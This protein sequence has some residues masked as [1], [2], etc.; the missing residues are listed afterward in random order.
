MMTMEAWTTDSIN[1]FS[2][3]TDMMMIMY[4][5]LIANLEGGVISTMMRKDGRDTYPVAKY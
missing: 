3:G 4:V 5:L 2:E 1:N